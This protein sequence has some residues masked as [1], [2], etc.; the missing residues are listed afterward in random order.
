MGMIWAISIAVCLLVLGGL[1][2]YAWSIPTLQ[3]F[4]PAI[5]RGP[6]DDR[7]IALTFD[8]GPAERFT[9]QILDIL[10][11]RNVKAT[12]FLCG[13]HVD[14]YPEI[15][16]RIHAEG[17]TLGNH[18]YSHPFLYFRSRAFLASE[19]NRTQEAIEK[20]VGYRPRFFRPPY[21]ARWLG[22]YSVLGKRNLRLV[23]WSDTGY[24]WKLDAEVLTYS[25]AKGAFAGIAL[26][27]ASVRQDDDST[28][29]IYGKKISTRS[30]L[31]GQ[32]AAPRTTHAFLNAVRGAKGQ[33]V[34]KAD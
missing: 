22:L 31:T 26:D 17:H 10:R 16:R 4:G 29:A 14:R 23:N 25:R 27:G 24:D 2:V 6:T 3:L 34:A 28:R 30:A 19:I 11:E 8:D 5:L 20:V 7:R 33:A 32:V 18:T 1:Y 9:E 13:E 12:F 15:V 21:G